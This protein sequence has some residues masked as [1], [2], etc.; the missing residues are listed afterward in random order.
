MVVS[1]EARVEVGKGLLDIGELRIDDNRAEP[2]DDPRQ[3]GGRNGRCEE[4]HRA[5]RSPSRIRGQHP[6]GDIA[7][8]AG[9]GAGY[10]TAHH[11]TARGMMKMAMARSQLLL[12]FGSI[13][14]KCTPFGP[15]TAE[16]LASM[17]SRPPTALT[18]KN[19]RGG[20][21]R[22]LDEELDHVD[23]QD[24]PEA[25]DRGEDDV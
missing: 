19:A 11:W 6:L 12:K 4:Q 18:A 8:P 14:R 25:G 5:E 2:D 23:D 1:E 21:G 9:L 15:V 10:Q 17:E 13:F 24:A 22:H 16:S 7:A 3:A 20:D